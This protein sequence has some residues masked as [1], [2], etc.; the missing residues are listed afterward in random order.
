MGVCRRLF[1]PFFP[2]KQAPRMPPKRGIVKSGNAGN[3]SKV[4]KP[5][6][7]AAPASGEKPLFPPGSKYPLSLLHE[8][9]APMAYSIENHPPYVLRSLSLI[10][11]RFSDVKSGVRRMAGR[12]LSSTRYLPFGLRIEPSQVTDGNPC[13]AK[14][15]RWLLIL[16]PFE[17]SQ[18][19]ELGARICPSGT[20]STIRDAFGS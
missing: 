18:Q 8:R 20:T 13:L 15:G 14:A 6:P 4:S 19:E 12:S 9:Y 16:C 7:E 1:N 2:S 5:P 10:E 17:Q 3:S 11:Q